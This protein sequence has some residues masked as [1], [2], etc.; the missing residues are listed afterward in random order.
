ME[1]EPKDHWCN[2]CNSYSKKTTKVFFDGNETLY[3]KLVCRF[4]DNVSYNE[5][6][7]ELETLNHPSGPPKN[8]TMIME[9][10]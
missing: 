8:F 10:E 6:K 5:Y 7:L 9:L 2:Q 3:K 1:L 4:C